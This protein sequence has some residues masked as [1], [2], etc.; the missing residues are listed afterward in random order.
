MRSISLIIVLLLVTACIC[1]DDEPNSFDFRKISVKWR[2]EVFSNYC[3]EEFPTDVGSCESA[4]SADLVDPDYNQCYFNINTWY[5]LFVFPIAIFF[6]ALFLAVVPVIVCWL[7]GALSPCCCCHHI[8]F[9]ICSP[10]ITLLTGALCVFFG[11]VGLV[12]AII[13]LVYAFAMTTSLYYGTEPLSSKFK[14]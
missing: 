11:L 1:A 7:C 8:I 5:S 9:I 2:P 14:G 12:V 10:C 6:T 4:C 13:Y 3:N